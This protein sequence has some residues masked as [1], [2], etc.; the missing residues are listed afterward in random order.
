MA[1]VSLRMPGSASAEPVRRDSSSAHK[2][3]RLG[4]GAPVG[5]DD[6]GA[7]RVQ[8]AHDLRADAFGAAGHECGAERRAFAPDG[9]LHYP[10]SLMFRNAA[11]AHGSAR[12][13]AARVRACKG[14]T[15]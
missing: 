1:A 10:A 13:M 8:R 11:L 9:E 4:G 7:G 5:D 12:I 3:L 14:R 2:R 6:V 15:R